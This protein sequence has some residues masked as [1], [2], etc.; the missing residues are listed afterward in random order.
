MALGPQHHED[1]TSTGT[2]VTGR[3]AYDAATSHWQWSDQMFAIHGFEPGEIVPTTE[4]VVAHQHP[5]DRDR[6]LAAIRAAVADGV[7][8]SSFHRLVDA[9]GATRS[10]VVVGEGAPGP[11]G[12][13]ARVTGY[14]IDVTEPQRA[15]LQDEVRDAVH[16]FRA[17]A[18]VIEQAKGILM[19]HHGISDDEAFAM[20][21]EH[22]QQT[23]VKVHTV[24]EQMIRHVVVRDS[25]A[26][27]LT[28]PLLEHAPRYD[29]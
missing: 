6:V 23:N 27:L 15:R 13:L 7:P 11:D 17:R 26:P 10:V 29:S 22:S 28:V 3:F 20:L 5:E 8:F 9:T 24:A 16:E 1:S 2:R 25:T 14:V 21:R 4:L 12:A 19:Q 18:A